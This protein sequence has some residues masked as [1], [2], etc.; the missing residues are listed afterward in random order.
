[1]KITVTHAWLVSKLSEQRLRVVAKQEAAQEFIAAHTRAHEAEASRAASE[2]V[3]GGADPAAYTA[4][5]R[6]VYCPAISMAEGL[7]LGLDNHLRRLD[8][9]T[10]VLQRTPSVS[11][12]L[13]MSKYL[14]SY[15]CSPF[16]GVMLPDPEGA[17][18]EYAPTAMSLPLKLPN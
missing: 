17:H 3:A 13:P 18:A 7:L 12:T 14:S 1:M 6:R 15:V 16:D 9:A 8:A 4:K 10:E 11:V 5:G 2:R